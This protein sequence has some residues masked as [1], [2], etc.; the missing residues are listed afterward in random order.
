M[1]EQMEI[2]E[3]I[4]PVFSAIHYFSE[5][6]TPSEEKKQTYLNFFNAFKKRYP[7]VRDKESKELFKLYVSAHRQQQILEEISALIGGHK[8]N[9]GYYSLTSEIS[10]TSREVM[11]WLFSNLHMR[12]HKIIMRSLLETILMYK[13]FEVYPE[14]SYKWLTGKSSPNVHAPVRNGGPR[15]SKKI[16]NGEKL[17]L[18]VFDTGMI[19]WIKTLENGKKT[20]NGTEQKLTK[21][22][23]WAKINPHDLLSAY[24]K[25]LDGVSEGY[26]KLNRAVHVYFPE[27]IA[28]VEEEWYEND[29]N[30]E[31]YLRLLKEWF[32]LS[33]DSLF[34]A[35]ILLLPCVNLP[36]NEPFPIGI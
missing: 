35:S 14:A 19:E 2:I 5:T 33:R 21:I 28:A 26:S 22:A 1:D 17:T 10:L 25:A 8:N 3:A 36:L 27:T 24:S 11:P 23:N 31:D 29:E 34:F 7:K 16:I 32:V 15:E 4:E 30:P 18:I 20:R 12:S 6:D 9:L 13:Y